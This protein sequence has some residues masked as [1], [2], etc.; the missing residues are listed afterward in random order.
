MDREEFKHEY[1]L[2]KLE[3]ITPVKR[4]FKM[5]VNSRVLRKLVWRNVFEDFTS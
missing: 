3:L 5:L 2:E 4:D 1:G